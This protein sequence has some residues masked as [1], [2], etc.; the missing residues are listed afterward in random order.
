MRDVVAVSVW[1]TPLAA[2][3]LGAFAWGAVAL[4][5]VLA[6]RAEGMG[7]GGRLGRPL[8]E[9]ARL[10][11]QR[12]ISPLSADRLLWRS[13][14]AGLV[15][16][17]MLMV[18]V[19]PLGRWTLSDLDV[20]VVWFNA[21]DVAVWAFVWMAGWGANS[22]HPLVGGY[23]FLALALGYE[24]PLMFALVGPAIAAHS[25]NVG[26][27]ASTQGHV[28]NLLWMPVAFVVYCIGVLAFSVQGPFGAPIGADLG[29][30]VRAELSGVDRLLFDGGRVALLVAGAAFAVPM[31]LG[32]GSGSLLPDWVWTLV[33]T[34]LLVAGFV[35]VGRRLPVLRPQLLL[36]VGWIILLPAALVQDLVV[37]VVAVWVR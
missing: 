21:M 30:G 26:A 10:L 6:A 36:E 14:G 23:R 27:I 9:A 35:W 24:L 34:A 4:D 13:G 11:R 8:D 20:G 33:K 29:G 12:R 16:A 15:V 7:A 2:A 32:G 37:A 28:W 19:I 5:G 31:F 18:A 1:W 17:A 22:V 25:L 3:L